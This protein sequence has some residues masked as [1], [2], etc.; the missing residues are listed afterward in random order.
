M[1]RRSGEA[2]RVYTRRGADWTKRFPR[3]VEAVKRLRASSVL[4]DGEG[5]VC[6]ERGLAVFDEIHSKANDRGVILY[7]FDLLELDGDDLRELGLLER[8]KRL[9]KLL[10]R[11]KGGIL[12]NDHFEQDGALVFEHACRLGCEGI[13]AK[14]VDAPYRSGRSKSWIKVKNRESPAVRRAEEGTF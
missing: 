2:V 13:V 6:D 1:V 3:V 8:K 7:A 11:S 4:L 12:Y 10:A 5:V 9:K 14:R